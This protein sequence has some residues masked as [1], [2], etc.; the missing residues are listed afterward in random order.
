ML[1]TFHK[2]RETKIQKIAMNTR[3]V[4]FFFIKP[5]TARKIKDTPRYISARS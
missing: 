3:F 5:E 1:A 2:D 4:V